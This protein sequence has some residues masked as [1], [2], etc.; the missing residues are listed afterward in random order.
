MKKAGLFL[1]VA[2][3]ML[4]FSGQARISLLGASFAAPTI[5]GKDNVYSPQPGE[6]IYDTTDATFWGY[7]QTGTW[8]PLGSSESATPIGTVIAFAAANCPAGYLSANGAEVSRTEYSSLFNVIG[9]AHGSG[10]G[11]TTFHVPDYRGRFLRGVDDTAG[12]DPDSS[13]RTAMNTGGNAQNN[14]GSVQGDGFR[15]HTHAQNAHSH[16]QNHYG[17]SI[18][19]T[20][21]GST[22]SFLQGTGSSNNTNYQLTTPA[23][24]TNQNTGG[25][26]TRPT[27]AY[28]NY[29]IKF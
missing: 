21:S 25:N 12:R 10:N 3:L 27:N 7:N 28:V 16:G 24:A 17:A 23:T 13:S 8:L 9:T 19:G 1:A 5:V 22:G 20:V 18:Y 29:C 14:V 6:I 26:E 2:G 15:S 11:S 4:P